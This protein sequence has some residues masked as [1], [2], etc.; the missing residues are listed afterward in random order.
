M[1]PGMYDN[2][3]TAGCMEGPGSST[4]VLIILQLCCS[5]KL[6]RVIPGT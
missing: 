4:G 2:C 6:L 1:Y 3:G 5:K